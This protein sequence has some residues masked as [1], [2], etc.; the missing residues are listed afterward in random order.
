MFGVSIQYDDESVLLWRNL[1]LCWLCCC[2]DDIH[3]CILY[4]LH[5]Y[6]VASTFSTITDNAANDMTSHLPLIEISLPVQVNT[7][8][9][10]ALPPSDLVQ[11]H[12]ISEPVIEDRWTWQLTCRVGWRLFQ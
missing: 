1:R 9:R 11:S 8:K 12:D 2:E 6:V 7:A 3:I 5:L 10:L 4:L